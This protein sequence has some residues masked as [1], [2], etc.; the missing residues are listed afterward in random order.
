MKFKFFIIITLLFPFIAFS[1]AVVVDDSANPDVI[2]IEISPKLPTPGA[3]VSV[4]VKSVPINLDSSKITWF[5]SGVA[6][7][8]D[9]GLKRIV[10][11]APASG[12]TL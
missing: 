8:S 1:Q 3:N 12:E 9:I 2:Y 7:Q 11:T 10:V 6:E 4:E 5:L